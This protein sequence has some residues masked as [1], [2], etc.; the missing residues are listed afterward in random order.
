MENDQ[1]RSEEKAKGS[2]AESKLKALFGHYDDTLCCEDPKSC[3]ICNDERSS[4]R[5]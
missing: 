1:D 3:G 2:E 5:R 4:P